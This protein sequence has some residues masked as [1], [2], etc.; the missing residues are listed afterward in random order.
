MDL[1]VLTFDQICDIISVDSRYM[2]PE[3]QP[4]DGGSVCSIT[5]QGM[6][7]DTYYTTHN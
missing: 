6:V 1:Q 7:V 3:F 4:S 5:T 2:S